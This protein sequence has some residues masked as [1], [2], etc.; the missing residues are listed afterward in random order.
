MLVFVPLRCAIHILCNL[1]SIIRSTNKA[2][3]VAYNS[4]HKEFDVVWCIKGL[5]IAYRI[6]LDVTLEGWT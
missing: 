4:V 3:D 6:N 2:L 1:H 5:I